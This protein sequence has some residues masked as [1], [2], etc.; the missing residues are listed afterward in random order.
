[1]PY[2]PSVPAPYRL[3][4]FHSATG[5]A[6]EAAVPAGVSPAAP[7]ASQR[8]CRKYFLPADVSEAAP[9]HFPAARCSKDFPADVLE[10][11]GSVDA[12]EAAGPAGVS[13]A[14]P[15]AHCRKPLPAGVSPAVLPGDVSPAEAHH[16]PDLPDLPGL[17]YRHPDH[18][19]HHNRCTSYKK[20]PVP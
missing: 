11:A 10:A 7:A 14:G 2:I 17:L 4:P 16:L 19:H 18:R 3:K 1:M 15:A 20:S 13:G 5:G 9:A 12:S 6:L 8:R